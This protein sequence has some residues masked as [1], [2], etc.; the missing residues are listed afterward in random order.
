MKTKILDTNEFLAEPSQSGWNPDRSVK[1]KKRRARPRTCW[2]LT[3][4]IFGVGKSWT[5][6]QH[7]Q[8][9][10]SNLCLL[11]HG[12]TDPQP[13]SEKMNL[14]IPDMFFSMAWGP[15]QTVQL[16]NALCSVPGAIWRTSINKNGKCQWNLA[17]LFLS[18]SS[19]SKGSTPGAKI[20][21]GTTGFVWTSW[22]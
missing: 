19:C 18:A 5:K 14:C 16:W 12:D 20:A 6:P 7:V 11:G 8:K 3:R 9:S 10:A 4:Q 21:P 22:T 15:H 13:P 2:R 1:P 17:H